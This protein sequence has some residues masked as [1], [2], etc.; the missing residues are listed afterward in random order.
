MKGF[1]L[2]GENSEEIEILKIQLSGITDLKIKRPDGK[3][4]RFQYI[5]RNRH[6][7]AERGFYAE[8]YIFINKKPVDCYFKFQKI[9]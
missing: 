6:N 3:K 5:S 4:Y 8:G 9:K 2:I 1:L 7:D